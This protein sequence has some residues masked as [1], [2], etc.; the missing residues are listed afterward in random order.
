MKS[1]AA[2]ADEIVAREGGFVD[3]PA[4]PGGATKHGVTIATARMLG[5]DLDHDGD[6][7]AEDVKRISARQARDIFLRD[8]FRKPRIHMLPEAIQ[9]SV[10]DMYVNAGSNAVRILQK[11]IGRM[12][13]DL[14]V[15]GV[16]GPQTARAAHLAMSMAPEHFVDA[17][18]IARRKYYYDLAA[19]RPASRKFACRTDGGKGGWIIRSEEFI[20]KKYH[21]SDDE[22]RKRVGSWA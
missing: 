18:G 2:L 13:L 14:N 20:S 6:V 22:H 15:D 11:L 9:G 5:L 21:L 8:Y 17:Y 10:F 16:I 3:D 1:V 19:R 4:D 7:D 12:G